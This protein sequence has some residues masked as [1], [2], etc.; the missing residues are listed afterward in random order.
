MRRTYVNAVDALPPELLERVMDALG[1]RACAIW[2]PERR[3]TQRQRRDMMALRMRD[4]G[5]SAW[6]I[7]CHLFISERTVF[8]IFAR[9]ES[10]GLHANTVALLR[11]SS[12]PSDTSDEQEQSNPEDHTRR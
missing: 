1:N 10:G 4:E 12:P 7:G 6:E 2:I 11:A 3:I 5:Y 8:R 9:A